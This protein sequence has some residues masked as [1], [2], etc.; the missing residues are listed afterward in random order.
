MSDA[1]GEPGPE[2]R[3][4]QRGP[5]P[6]SDLLEATPETAYFW[7]RVAGDGDLTRETITVR[8]G[9]KRAAEALA[10][11]AG[12]E[13]A[14]HRVAARESAHDASMVRYEEEYE[15]QVFGPTAERASAA[16]G[17][18]IG[19]QTGGYRFDAFSEYRPQLVRGLLEACG[20][21]CFRESAGSVGISFV[22]SD[23]RL[24]ETIRSLLA[25]AGPAVPT[26]ALS[27]TSSGGYYFGLAEGADTTGFA[28]W[29]YAGSERSGLYSEDRRTKLRRSV[30]RAT[31]GEVGEL[32]GE[33]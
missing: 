4:E 28:G 26:E 32:S 8:T 17:L 16:L 23:E 20:T 29:A 21:V 14:D 9:D 31:G 30:E 22:H 2:P 13:E 27:A 5:E 18:P 25:A 1:G 11:I 12:T 24:L 3:S 15:L 7:G 6:V 33:R 19:N 10:A